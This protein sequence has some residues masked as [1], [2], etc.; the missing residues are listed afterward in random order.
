MKPTQ[1]TYHE[2]QLAYGGFNQSLF[3]GQ[4]PDCLITLQREKHTMGYFSRERF[5]NRAGEKTDE[6]ALNPAYFA[7]G[8]MREALQTL[9]HEMCHLWQHHFGTPGRGR[10]HNA[11]WSKKMQS[12]GLMPSHTGKPGGNKTGDRMADFI[13]DGGVFDLAIDQ[14]VAKGFEM[15]WMDRFVAMPMRTQFAAPVPTNIKLHA[16]GNIDADDPGQLIRAMGVDTRL[17][18]TLDVNYSRLMQSKQGNRSKYF[19]PSCATNLWGKPGLNILC[20]DCDVSF[21]EQ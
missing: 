1:E 14:V 13:I 4:L 16:D 19:C 7:V 18:E 17:F 8:G 5:A 20:G 2:W 3:N 12:I 6:I 21:N 11:Q 9:A 15:K 10:Y